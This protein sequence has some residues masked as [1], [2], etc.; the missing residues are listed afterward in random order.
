MA[1]YILWNN[2]KNI[3]GVF[4]FMRPQLYTNWE[5]LEKNQ[6]KSRISMKVNIYLGWEKF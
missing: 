3:Q 5:N 4:S 6:I 2:N 1:W